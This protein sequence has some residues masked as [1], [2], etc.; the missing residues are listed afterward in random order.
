MDSQ[1]IVV[2]VIVVVVVAVAIAVGIYGQQKRTKQL[3]AIA[4]QQ[5]YQY[6]GQEA[7]L[8]DAL[9][10]FAIFSPARAHARTATDLLR[11]EADGAAAAL[12]DYGYSTGHG[13]NQ[14]VHTQ[15]VLLFESER[16]NLPGFALRPEGL[17]QKLGG[18]L[19]QQD[20]DFK[21]QPGFSKAY[22]LQGPDEDQLRALFDSEKL[23][24]FAQRHG[25][26]V[27][28]DGRKLLYY[29]AGKR[30]SPKS[31][32]SFVEEGL[33]VLHLLAGE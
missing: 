13:K 24:F 29:R 22:V 1:V 12:F 4:A 9:S 5:G 17:G 21:E 19:G 2:I 31:I 32:P 27:E 25:L 23:A 26:N 6:V 16:L 3:R 20:I 10:G 18:A 14:R 8:I 15:S 11:T 7:G 33:A 28:G 30:V